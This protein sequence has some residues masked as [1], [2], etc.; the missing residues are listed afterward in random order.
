MRRAT[1]VFSAFLST[2]SDSFSAEAAMELLAAAEG[3]IRKDNN[4]CP[5][6]VAW[7]QYLNRTGHHSFLQML[8]SREC[9]HRWAETTF[10]AILK[11]GY[12]LETMLT[13]RVRKHPDHIFFRE[14]FDSA[15]GAWTYAEIGRRLR[16]LAGL[17]C[18]L[19]ADPRVA[20]FCENSIDSAC[21]DLACLVHC[22]FDTPLNIHFDAAALAWIFDR[23]GINIV[24]ADTEER[25]LRL[26]EARS[27][28]SRPVQIL[29][30]GPRAGLPHHIDCEFLQEAC[31]RLD[32]DSLEDLLGRRQNRPLTDIATVMFT[33]GSTGAPK[34]IAFTLY[35][36]ITKRF[37]RAAALPAVGDHEV[38]LCYLPLFHTFGRYLEML[39]TLYWGGTYVFA[40]NPSLETLISQLQEVHPTGL[41]GIPLR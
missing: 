8:P 16:N 29:V 41:I 37:S 24:I 32:L 4:D 15:Q 14:S 35:H 5:D 3:L 2:P 23:L 31:A 30:A 9:R 39:G 27:R 18:R 20:I 17:L 38:L 12:S 34:G 33:S 11:S 10:R 7:H 13:D 1:E 22:I 40:G 21:C 36:L 25:I 19:E 28:T 26:Q 6:A